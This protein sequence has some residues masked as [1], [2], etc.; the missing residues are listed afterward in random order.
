LAQWWKQSHLVHRVQP[1]AV[2]YLAQKSLGS[3]DHAGAF[4]V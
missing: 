3:L 4:E 2:G 1:D